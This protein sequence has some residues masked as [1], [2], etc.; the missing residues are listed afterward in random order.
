MKEKAK[1]MSKEE[2]E[3]VLKRLALEILE[4][5]KG[6]SNSLLVGIQRRGN[7]LASRL[8]QYIAELEQEKVV[9]GVLDITLYR[10]DLSLLHDQP[11]VHST[12][13]PVDITGKNVIL[14]DDVLYT[15]RTV[16]AALD[17]LMDLGRP[18][19][20]QLCVLIDRGHRELPIHPDYVGKNIPT[21][22]NEIVEV[23]VEELDGVDEVVICER[24]E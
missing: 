21:S 22:K 6:M 8:K 19:S 17:A 3:R 24:G 15:G 5:N 18:A 10:D 13:I 20:V 23:R 14:V 9:T 7:H 2:M 11:V 16:R 12:G 4:K 1:I